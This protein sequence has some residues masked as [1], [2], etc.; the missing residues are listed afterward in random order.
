MK[1]ICL[2]T[3][4]PVTI[5]SFIIPI[6]RYYQ[7]HTDWDISVICDDTPN[8]QD[9]LP[10]GVHYF[11]VSMKRGISLGGIS[12]LNRMMT[13]FKR[14]KFDLVQYCTPNASF[15]ASI[16]A[17]IAKIPVRLYC[18][19][20]MVYVSMKGIKR[21]IFK[22]IEKTICRLSTHIQ[23]DSFG[24]LAF[25]PQE[26]LYPAGKG[27]VVW[28]G[29]TG[30]IDLIQYDLSQKEAWRQEIRRKHGIKDDAF[31]YG[32]VGRITGDKG[33][34]ELLTAYAQVRQHRPNTL[35]LLVGKPEKEKSLD[36]KLL[37]WAKEQK[38]IIFAGPQSG[39]QRYYAAMD[40]FLLPSY[41]E[42]FGSVVI[43]AE[44]M[45]VPVIATDIPG[46]SEAMK[47]E[48][49]GLL[50]PKQ[51]APALAKAMERLYDHRDLC[52]QLGENGR[53]YVSER[54][55]QQTFYYYTMEDRKRLLNDR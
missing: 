36:Q 2:I 10:Q 1:K 22:S 5:R 52:R 3:T 8:F 49:S 17:K 12:A 39:I 41:R 35:L 34:N 13:I 25:G 27:S 43:E 37:A 15:Y 32:F 51:D 16:A 7:A 26:S 19:W 42:G 46:P 28:N 20:G 23:P 14:E 18:Q 44:A 24:N 40:V 55:E 6:I 33:T 4:V 38:D 29:S 50:V 30:G 9:E 54:F 31:V 45:E 53:Q 47:N 21:R 11:P 48:Y